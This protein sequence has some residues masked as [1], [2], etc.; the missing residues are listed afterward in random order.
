[1]A[2]M[3]F[4]EDIEHDDVTTAELTTSQ[5]VDCCQIKNCCQVMFHSGQMKQKWDLVKYQINYSPRKYSR[6]IMQNTL[7]AK[8]TAFATTPPKVNRFGWNLEQ[9]EP[10]VGGWPRQILSNLRD[11]TFDTSRPYT[12]MWQTHTDRH[13][14]A[15]NTR[16][17][18]ASWLVRVIKPQ[19]ASCQWTWTHKTHNS[20]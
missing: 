13:T 8:R 20:N 6:Q 17:S 11:P 2:V 16:A 5:V 19:Q 3:A 14:M 1:M 12:G 15:A 10:N 9:C 4:R 18:I 7:W